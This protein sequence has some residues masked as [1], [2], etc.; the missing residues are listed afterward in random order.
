MLGAIPPLHN[1]PSWRGDKLKH[2]NYFTFT[3]TEVRP[4]A[5][6]KSEVDHA[7]Q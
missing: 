3:F 4:V 5:P 1:T 7:G 2:R 6:K